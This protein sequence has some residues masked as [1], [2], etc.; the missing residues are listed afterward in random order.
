MELAVSATTLAILFIAFAVVYR[1]NRTSL[2]TGGILVAFVADSGFFVLLYAAGFSQ[3]AISRVVLAL[4]FVTWI[5]ASTFGVYFFIA[6]FLVN[7]RIVFR[8]ERRSLANSLTLIMAIALAIFAAVTI[9]IRNQSLPPWFLRI[10][11]GVISLMIFYL[12]HLISFLASLLLYNLAKPRMPQDFIIVLGAGLKDGKVTKLLAGRVK[13]AVDYGV[14]QK[15]KKGYAPT[16]VMSGGKGSDESRSEGEAMLD[17]AV[18]LGYDP[19]LVIVEGNSRNT[20]ENMAFSKELISA[21]TSKENP[22]CIIA[23]SDFHLLRA[24][25]FA[26]SA[27]MKLDGIGSKTAFYYMPNAMIRE[28]IAILSMRKKKLAITVASVFLIAAAFPT[29]PLAIGKALL[30]LW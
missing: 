5:F 17:C 22:R 12:I 26:K 3:N 27:G 20:H 24:G 29:I 23:T 14:K 19:E 21:S 10:W 9:V 30:F 18:E 2:W 15:A 28:Y 6:F 13:R 16:L 1:V 8:K 7:A 25:R 4:A 11:A